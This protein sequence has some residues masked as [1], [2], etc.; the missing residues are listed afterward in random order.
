MTNKENVVGKAGRREWIALV[1]LVLPTIL[2]ALDMTVLHLAVPHLS[3][4]LRPTSSQLLWILDIYGFMIGGFLI[5]MGTLGDRIGRRK[6]LMIGAAL[7]GIA[8]VMAAFS[9]TANMLIITRALL[10]IAGATLMPST[11][12]LIRNMFHDPGERTRA[13]AVWMTGFMVGTAI[14]PLVGGAEDFSFY[15]KEAPGL[16]V[17][18]GVTPRDQ[19]MSKAAPNHNPGF[20]VDESALVVGVRTLAS[21]ATD[22]LY[23]HTSP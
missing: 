12:S 22:Y 16:F 8:S 6:L 13:I 1:V 9:S 7:F 4:D 3:A 21:L 15:A 5:T 19:D 18:L 10:G 11:L 23:T 14:G 17:F 2:I 20:F